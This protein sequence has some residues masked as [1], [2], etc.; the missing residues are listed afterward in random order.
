[1]RKYDFI[2]IFFEFI[3]SILT[4]INASNFK[5]IAIFFINKEK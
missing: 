5:F 1:M 4:F 2:L 3:I